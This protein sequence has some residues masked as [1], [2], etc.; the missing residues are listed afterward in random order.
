MSPSLLDVCVLIALLDASHLRH[1]DAHLWLAAHRSAGWAT[2]PL[3]QN[4]CVRIMAQQSYPRPR[5]LLEVARRLGQATSA[6]D[7]RFYPDDISLVTDG[8]CDLSVVVSPNRLTDVYL[9]A[10]AVRH[11][12]RLVT[13]DQRIS[14]SAV[15]GATADHLLVL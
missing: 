13:F 5:P 15:P 4:G 7:H 6:P 1:R 8:T 12:S 9:L 2:C 11:G 3:V 10:L 14:L